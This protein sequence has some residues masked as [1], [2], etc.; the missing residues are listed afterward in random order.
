MMAFPNGHLDDEKWR[1]QQEAAR[2]SWLAAE[3]QA[4][5]AHR[6][7]SEIRGQVGNDI[8][9]ECG[10]KHRVNIVLSRG[11]HLDGVDQLSPF[12]IIDPLN[13]SDGGLK[14]EAQDQLALLKSQNSVFRV[15]HRLLRRLVGT[16]DGRA[17]A[18][19]SQGKIP[20]PQPDDRSEISPKKKEVL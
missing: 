17:R 20:M 18:G 10:R 2:R 11:Q 19:A 14:D 16:F 12:T 13:G 8:I 4:N 7:R 3:R 9:C 5:E 1:L 15:I 6:A